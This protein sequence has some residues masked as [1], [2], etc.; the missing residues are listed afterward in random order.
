MNRFVPAGVRQAELALLNAPFEEDGWR[1][2]ILQVTEAAGFDTANMVALGGPLFLPL[3]FFVGFEAERAA[4]TFQDP[5]LWGECNWRINTV[6]RPMAIQ[7]DADYAAYRARIATGNYDDVMLDL[8]MESGCQCAVLMDDNAFLGL[9]LSRRRNRGPLDSA[10]LENFRHLR[11]CLQRAVRMQLALDGQNARELL[12]NGWF[13]DS[14]TLLLDGHGRVCALNEDAH[15]LLSANS[16]I[17]LDNAF[18]RLK[19][20]VQDEHLH[21][22]LTQILRPAAEPDGPA[23]YRSQV[24]GT[25]PGED[26]GLAI[27]IVR[28]PQREHGL[29][30]DARAAVTVKPF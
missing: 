5:S 28:L 2:A 4:A 16:P 25:V 20:R 29:A 3:N 21:R 12:E 10:A 24:R 19:C 9:A 1:R 26:S 7:H 8:D 27:S 14:P 6:T 17:R 18:L 11:I 13:G 22:A 30:F 15:N 23:V